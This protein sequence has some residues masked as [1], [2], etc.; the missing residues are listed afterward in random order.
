[1]QIPVYQVKKLP[2]THTLD[3]VISKPAWKSIPAVALR[4]TTDSQDPR[5]KTEAK[6]AWT[7]TRLWAA[8]HCE[9]THISA[10]LTEHDDMMLWSENVVEIFLD[11]LGTGK[12]YYEFQVN[13][14][15]AGFDGIV[16]NASG[17]I[18]VGPGEGMQTLTAWNPASYKHLVTGIGK[19]NG[20][21]QED[22]Y[23]DTEL[24]IGFEELY[25]APHNPPRPGDRWRFNAYRVDSGPW[26][27]ELYA[28]NPTGMPKFHVSELFG[29]ME[30]EG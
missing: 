25:M 17:K 15:N 14:R 20:T 26:G 1:M 28:W 18:G 6:F 9:D 21:A 4:R 11:P 22:Q 5:Q 10:Q 29:V 23:W 16:H 27:Q 7:G 19:F 13:C 3:G 12:V 2:E 8:F 24:C 30:F